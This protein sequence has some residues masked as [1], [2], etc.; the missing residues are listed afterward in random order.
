MS[1]FRYHIASLA[2]VFLALGIGIFVGT[3][4][5]GAPVVD[6]QTRLIK[7]LEKNVTA[8][9]QEAGE[10]EKNEDALRG[11]VPRLVQGKLSGR[12]VLLVQTEPGQSADAVAAVLREAGAE[13]VVRITLPAPAWRGG[14]GESLSEDEVTKQAEALAQ[15]LPDPTEAAI[16]PFRDR[17]Q[18]TGETGDA[19][20]AGFR[21]IV[22]VSGDGAKAGAA[23]TEQQRQQEQ[24]GPLNLARMRDVPLLRGLH[25]EV[26]AVAAEPL[27][28]AVSLMPAYQSVDVA[29]VDNADRAAGQIAIVFA[30]TGEKN[31]YGLKATAERVLPASL[32]ELL[33]TPTAPTAPPS[34]PTP[35]ASP[36]PSLSPSPAP[37]AAPMMVRP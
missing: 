31:N 20:F 37:A 6:R 29:T 21:L 19:L 14:A 25:A 24:Q 5:V 2:A 33:P 28:A 12:R 16:K 30:L 8:Q 32:S 10:R 17:G 15:I 18:I 23:A 26:T 35:F 7:N 36:S 27:E 1:D 22:F 9:M 13:T 11:L 4:F 3:A 34:V